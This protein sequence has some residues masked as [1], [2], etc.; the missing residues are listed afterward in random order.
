MFD[1]FW[2]RWVNEYLPLLQKRQKWTKT[3]PNFFED[4]LVLIANDN[5][6]RNA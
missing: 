2:K 4:D 5:L 6:P 3:F 1:I